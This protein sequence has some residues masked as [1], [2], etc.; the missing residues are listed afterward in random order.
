MSMT[1]PIADMITRIRNG[2]MANLSSIKSPSSKVRKAIC[3]VLKGEGYIRD[4]QEAEHANNKRTLTI[5][6]KYSEGEPVIREI[7]R[8]SKPGRREYSAIKKLQKYFNG[9][10]VA[11]LST[12]QGVMSDY[13]ARA[14][15]IGGEILC[16]VF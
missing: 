3:E 6:L 8:I 1:D 12:S 4:Y 7:R 11:I 14:K 2:Q 10:G 5:E 9:L 15:N 16:V 13:D